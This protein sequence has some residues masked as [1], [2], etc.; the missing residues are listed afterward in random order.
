MQAWSAARVSIGV[1]VQREQREHS[2]GAVRTLAFGLDSPAQ[3]PQRLAEC[4]PVVAHHSLSSQ[5]RP[6]TSSSD[7]RVV[8]GLRAP[9]P[10]EVSLSL[11]DST[12]RKQ[13]F[14]LLP[15]CTPC[16]RPPVAVAV[17]VAVPARTHA[18]GALSTTGTRTA[19]LAFSRHPTQ[20]AIT[21]KSIQH[22][23]PAS[24][25]VCR[26]SRSMLP[27]SVALGT[28]KPR[29]QAAPSRTARRITLTF[30]NQTSLH[31][32]SFPVAFSAPIGRSKT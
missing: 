15:S 22:L 25:S 23:Q 12:H 28:P 7:Q 3:S 17:A 9:H 2:A 27:R 26:M 5:L 18:H 8:T 32:V 31:V 19:S 4:P 11:L 20:S 29:L 13:P 10:K 24:A 21:G 16:Y 6:Q 1:P 30:L 14:S